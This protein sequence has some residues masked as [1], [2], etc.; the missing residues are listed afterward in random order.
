A[1]RVSRHERLELADE[2]RVPSELEVRVD[3]LL[4]RRQVE[5]LEPGPFESC[6]RLVL[7]LAERRASPESEPFAQLARRLRAALLFPRDES[8]GAQLLEAVEV[9]ALACDVEPVAVPVR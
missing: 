2:I 7:E 6:E 4:E 8:I 9:D 3:P 1:H 5:L